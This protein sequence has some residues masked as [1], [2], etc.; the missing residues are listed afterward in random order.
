M[1][2]YLP[3]ALVLNNYKLEISLFECR[4]LRLPGVLNKVVQSKEHCYSHVKTMCTRHA[5]LPSFKAPKNDICTINVYQALLNLYSPV[6]DTTLL[7]I[8]TYV[9]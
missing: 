6:Y 8:S 5:L 3:L 4:T 1:C 2:T 7:A 9:R